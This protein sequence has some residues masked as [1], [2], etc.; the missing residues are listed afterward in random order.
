MSERVKQLIENDPQLGIP[1][2]RSLCT[3]S[4]MRVCLIKEMGKHADYPVIAMIDL[5][6]EAATEMF[7]DEGHY[8]LEGEHAYDLVCI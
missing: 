2:S 6:N 1:W 4:G 3:R 8:M 7:T 5:G